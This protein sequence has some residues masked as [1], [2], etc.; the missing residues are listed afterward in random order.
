MG[1]VEVG[2]T[3]T[4]PVISRLYAGSAW[5]VIA[6]LVFLGASHIVIAVLELAGVIDL[7]DDLSGGTL[8]GSNDVSIWVIIP[9]EIAAAVLMFVG[10]RIGKDRPLLGVSAMTGALLLFL[11]RQGYW[12]WPVLVLWA[13]VLAVSLRRLAARRAPV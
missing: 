9:I 10:Y 7:F 2:T 6:V 3:S 13:F 11:A 8:L 1:S 4:R 5:I 12:M